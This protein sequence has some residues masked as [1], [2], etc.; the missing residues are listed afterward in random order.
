[1]PIDEAA[2]G[3]QLREFDCLTFEDRDLHH[4]GLL[5]TA[6]CPPPPSPSSCGR[7]SGQVK[8][9]ASVMVTSRSFTVLRE[10]FTIAEATAS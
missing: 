8:A 5:L 6:F 7:S 2:M 4:F 3:S 1:M 9:A 10:V